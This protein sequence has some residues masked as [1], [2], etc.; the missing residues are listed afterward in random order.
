[1]SIV[2]KFH[3]IFNKHP[4]T[5][6]GFFK[7]WNQFFIKEVGGAEQKL[8]RYVKSIFISYYR[9]SS[10]NIWEILWILGSQC[11]YSRHVNIQCGQLCSARMNCSKKVKVHGD[12]KW[13]RKGKYSEMKSSDVVLQI[14]INIVVHGDQIKIYKGKCNWCT[15]HVR[16]CQK[17]LHLVQI[18]SFWI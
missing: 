18:W 8:D 11:T 17:I 5:C 10:T 16:K 14:K 6:F 2:E 9:I 1:M 7:P 3:T 4:I 15:R 13:K 12:K